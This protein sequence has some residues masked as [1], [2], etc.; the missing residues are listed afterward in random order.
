M[1]TSKT[2]GQAS[3]KTSISDLGE[4]LAS[5]Y[6]DRMAARTAR[7]AKLS[8][9]QRVLLK[10]DEEKTDGIAERSGGGSPG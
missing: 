6:E 5:A 3:R 10:L 1:A 8:D 7:G 2:T 9:E 4:S